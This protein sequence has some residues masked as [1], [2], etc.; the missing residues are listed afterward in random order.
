MAI[1][2]VLMVFTFKSTETILGD[3]GTCSW[4][5]K[6]QRAQLCEYAVCTRNAKHKS[7]QG[8]E[9]HGSAFLI[10]RIRDVVPTPRDIDE[11]PDRFLIRFSEY[12]RVSLPNAWKGDRV[13]TRYMDERELGIHFDKLKWQPLPES[14]SSTPPV[15]AASALTKLS[16]A[17]ARPLLARQYGVPPDAIEIIIRG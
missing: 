3:G 11:R 1:G 4:H 2:N 9:P 10:G 12:A 17:E 8:K 13:P 7:V 15:E 5:V 6:P 16:M 14:A